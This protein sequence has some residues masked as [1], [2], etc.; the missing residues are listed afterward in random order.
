MVRQYNLQNIDMNQPLLVN[1]DVKTNHESFFLPQF[2]SLTGLSDENRNNF[3][4]MKDLAEASNMRANDRVRLIQNFL[5]QMMQ[6]SE[7]TLKYWDMQISLNPQAIRA[8]R[9]HPGILKLKHEKVDLVYTDPN[10]LDRKCQQE[11]VL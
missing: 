7:D 9:M 3:K 8:Y 6:K 5:K 10:A 2:C 11:M 1:V 4:L